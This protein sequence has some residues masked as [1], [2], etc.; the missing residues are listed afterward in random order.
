VTPS[1]TYCVVE[2][3]P[4]AGYILDNT[5]HAVVVKAEETATTG[6]VIQVAN[7][8]V[9]GP[10]LPLTGAEGTTM[11]TLAGLALVAIAG[12]G[13]LVRRARAKV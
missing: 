2:V 10:V 11:F 1:R 13:F 4:P 8:P 5:P 7:V 9:P 12:G 3:A 6:A